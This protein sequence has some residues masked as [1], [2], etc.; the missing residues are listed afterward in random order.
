M[1]DN[2]EEEK[3]EEGEDR[4]GGYAYPVMAREHDM[5]GTKA[6]IPEGSCT[7][8]KVDVVG[9]GISD[10]THVMGISHEDVPNHLHHAKWQ[11]IYVSLVGVSGS[12][13]LVQFHRVNEASLCRIYTLAWTIMNQW[14][15]SF[16]IYK[17]LENPLHL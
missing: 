12:V 8:N 11:E 6:S 13:I 9:E 1:K 3:E 15:L 2:K 7:G 5:V 10:R 16:F 4:L 17:Y 14:L